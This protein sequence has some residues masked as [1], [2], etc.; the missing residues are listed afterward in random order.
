LR[1]SIPA[2]D[3]DASFLSKFTNQDMLEPPTTGRSSRV[4][5]LKAPTALETERKMKK[6]S[7]L[8]QS[9]SKK[10]NVSRRSNVN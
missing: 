9:E 8:D 3:P 1:S 10:S 7:N 2:V 5:A 4:S 6:T